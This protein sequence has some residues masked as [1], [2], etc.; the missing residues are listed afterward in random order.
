MG[1]NN[2][3]EKFY[4]GHWVDR[5]YLNN[6][7]FYDLAATR[8]HE[9]SHKSGC[10]GSSEFTYKLTDLIEA[11]TDAST[12]SPSVRLN[13]SAIENVFNNLS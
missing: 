11:L 6:G 4:A 2:A 8:L 5:T 7:N 13:L 1:F 3:Y 12:N 9:I 10:G